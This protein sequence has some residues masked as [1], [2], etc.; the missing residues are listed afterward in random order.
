MGKRV[1]V[2]GAGAA[3]LIAAW[4]AAANGASVTLLE[5][6]QASGL[7]LLITGAGR[8]NVTNSNDID[9]FIQ[10]YFSKGRF[11]YPAFNNFFREDLLKLLE[12]EGL[13]FITEPNGKIFPASGKA[14]DI[15]VAL[16]SLNIK[17]NVR[18]ITGEAVKSLQIEDGRIVG[19]NTENS[20]YNAD[21]VILAAGGTSW[22]GTGSSGDGCRLAASIGHK[23]EMLRPALVPIVIE[24][25]WLREL[26]GI[27]LQ[28]TDVQLLCNGRKKASDRGE[29]LFTH[30]GLSGPVI[31]RLSRNLPDFSLKQ[32]TGEEAAW[33]L[34]ID[35]APN[36]SVSSLLEIWRTA[37][38]AN[39]ARSLI[40]C[41]GEPFPARLTAAL[42]QQYGISRDIRAADVGMGKLEAMA[43]GCKGLALNIAGTRGYRE[44]MVT[45]GGVS[46]KE[47]DP[48][49]MLSR[50][51][52][53]LYFAGEVLDID[54]DTGGYNLQAA[55]STGVLA[56]LHAAS[57]H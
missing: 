56:G 47:V 27:S 52:P 48:R 25:E 14:G 51:V 6:M 33:Q 3:G 8:C 11:L 53:G 24:A 38:S 54:G 1:L 46:L 4:S 13:R 34:K 22:P 37:I 26:K 55:F 31:L 28:Q 50:L 57:D 42:M 15:L 36:A 5:K 49:S 44:A 43:S 7:K 17:V 20:S 9:A 21:A 10:K 19:V 16:N 18:V 41:L 2:I 45:A 12:T 32:K 40:N 23:I 29:L 39:P 30:F 35:L